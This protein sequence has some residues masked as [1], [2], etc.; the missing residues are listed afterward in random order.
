MKFGDVITIDKCNHGC[1]IICDEVKV[2]SGK[3]N[4]CY[5]SYYE[6]IK[7]F[8]NINGVKITIKKNVPVGSGLGGGSANAAAALKGI[9]K[10]FDLALSEN[11]LESIGVKIG[12]D[13]PFFIRGGVQFGEG[14]GEKLTK[15][16]NL[17][18]PKTRRV[19]D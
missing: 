8:P 13:V 19:N 3:N 7:R 16:K 11:E 17:I 18:L 15:I 10:L 14:I 1:Y 2:P 4:V 12:A 6:L 5:K 9:C